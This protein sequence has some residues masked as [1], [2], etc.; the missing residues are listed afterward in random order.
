M[1]W[2]ARYASLHCLCQNGQSSKLPQPSLP[3]KT[4]PR[5][6]L[7]RQTR[8]L[9]Q[10]QPRHEK[11]NGAAAGG[12]AEVAAG[13]DAVPASAAGVSRVDSRMVASGGMDDFSAAS[14]ETAPPAC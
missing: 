7:M 4:A 6:S 8:Q 9:P 11:V 12:D 13:V 2:D 10:R 5:L 3:Y 14:I 1:A